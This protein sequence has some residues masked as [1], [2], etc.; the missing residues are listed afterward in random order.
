MTY[1]LNGKLAFSYDTLF[2]AY[3]APDIT[4][5]VRADLLLAR[6]AIDNSLTA[7]LNSALQTAWN[8]HDT[9]RAAFATAVKSNRASVVAALQFP[10]D[11]SQTADLDVDLAITSPVPSTTVEVDQ[12]VTYQVTITNRGTQVWPSGSVF[13]DLVDNFV[14]RIERKEGLIIKKKRFFEQA[15]ILFDHLRIGS[16]EMLITLD[17]DRKYSLA[18]GQDAK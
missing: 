8:N 13:T 7:A 12:I 14:V 6:P 16:I 2:I 3:S 10:L 1:P 11:G 18:Q 9:D 17:G 15:A 4:P 5:T